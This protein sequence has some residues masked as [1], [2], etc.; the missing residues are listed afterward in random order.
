MG[1]SSDHDKIPILRSLLS[2]VGSSQNTEQVPHLGN[3][4]YN[5]KKDSGGRGRGARG[6]DS[7]RILKVEPRGFLQT[8]EHEREESRKIP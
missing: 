5:G 2:S 1:Y 3:D 6:L 4:K 7:G 8:L